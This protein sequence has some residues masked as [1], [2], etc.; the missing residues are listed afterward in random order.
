[1]I[2]PWR[3]GWSLWVNRH[4]HHELF[5]TQVTN[6]RLLPG[7][8]RVSANGALPW[9]LFERDRAKFIAAN[10]TLEIPSIEPLTPMSDLES[11]GFSMRSTVPGYACPA[12]RFLEGRIL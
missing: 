12:I 6:W 2:E 9:I 4:L 10:P 5:H 1:M 11:G 7:G 3:T 8:T